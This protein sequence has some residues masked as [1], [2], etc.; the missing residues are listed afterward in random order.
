VPV[1]L[2]CSDASRARGE[3]LFATASRVERWI[4]VEQCGPWGPPAVPLSRVGDALA[5]HLTAEAAGHAARLVLLRHPR[6][7][8]CPPGRKVFL[9]DSMP[10]REALW[11]RHFEHDDELAATRLP[12]GDDDPGGW[13]R[14]DGPLF[15][16]CTHGKHDR[17]CAL[18]GR[19]VAEALAARYPERTWE[20]SHIGGDRFAA[21][22]LVLPDGHYLSRLEAAEAPGAVAD[23]LAGRLPL[24]HARGRS[25]LPLPVQAAQHFARTGLDRD[26]LDDLTLSAQ[27]PDGVDT[28]V[29]RLAGAVD[30]P[31]VE[32][33]VRY[34]RRA[35]EPAR[36]TCGALRESVAPRFVCLGLETLVRT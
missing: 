16:V 17:C 11:H 20:C 36:L 27:R 29:V 19:P 15:L 12:A 33:R 9:V 30:L 14:F 25:S 13:S 32:V 8:E 26:G 31:D 18:R 2:P 6:G 5:G 10:G 23:L 1:D 4:L 22:L 28:W 21:N 24:A 7:I 35:V 34:D 3:P